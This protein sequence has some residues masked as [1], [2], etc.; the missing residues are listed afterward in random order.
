MNDERFSIA[1]QLILSAPPGQLEVV[2]K[3]LKLIAEAT[4][5][6][7]SA[8]QIEKL[9]LEH[10]STRKVTQSERPSDTPLEGVFFDKIEE[11]KKNF[12]SS[13][14]VVSMTSVSEEAKSIVVSCYSE[15]V[16]SNNCRGGSWLAKWKLDGRTL[17]GDVQIYAICH[18]HGITRVQSSRSFGPFTVSDANDD[19]SLATAVLEQISAWESNVMETLGEMYDSM[20]DCLKSLRRVLPLTRK[21][22]DWSVHAHRMAKTLGEGGQ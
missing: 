4:G 2:L 22:L 7:L 12:Y 6:A 19:E 16:D 8:D 11:Y 14:G 5:E 15:H 10:D 17:S 18:E 1:R 20:P 3:D 9:R 21:R 13:K